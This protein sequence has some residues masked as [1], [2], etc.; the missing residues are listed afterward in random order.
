MISTLGTF[1]ED[2]NSWWVELESLASL[3]ET[4]KAKPSYATQLNSLTYGFVSNLSLAAQVVQVGFQ[5]PLGGLQL[6]P[7]FLVGRT[8]QQ[9]MFKKA[10]NKLNIITIDYFQRS[11]NGIGQTSKLY[12]KVERTWDCAKWGGGGGIPHGCESINLVEGVKAITLLLCWCW[13][14]VEKTLKV[15]DK[16]RWV[17][18][19]T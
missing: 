3:M 10:H 1:C 13:L 16:H 9:F 4:A 7:G 18:W 11:L 5:L 17:L 8:F 6:W 14:P 2:I 12:T 15:L 19:L